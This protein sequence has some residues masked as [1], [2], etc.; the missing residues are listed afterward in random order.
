MAIAHHSPCRG[1]GCSSIF[2]N[3]NTNADGSARAPACNCSGVP[4]G[5]AGMA[6]L[7][8]KFGRHLRWMR[9]SSCLF[10]LGALSSLF[11]SLVAT[12]A[13]SPP[14]SMSLLGDCQC[15][16][17]QSPQGLSKEQGKPSQSRA[18]LQEQKSPFPTKLPKENVA[19]KEQSGTQPVCKGTWVSANPSWHS[20]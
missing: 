12:L 2:P 1:T 11:L 16:W 8:D 18:A 4:K 14:G 10:L 3:A 20:R 19:G 6:L 13:V 15:Q 7:R 5:R 9:S 17:L